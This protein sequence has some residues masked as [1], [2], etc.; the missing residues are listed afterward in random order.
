M[1][2]TIPQ[3]SNELL[4][5]EEWPEEIDQNHEA[6]KIVIRIPLRGGGPAIVVNDQVFVQEQLT[7]DDVTLRPDDVVRVPP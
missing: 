5:L 3:Q 4:L 6:I 7:S 1:P 2:G